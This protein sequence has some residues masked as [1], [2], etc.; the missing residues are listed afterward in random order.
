MDALIATLPTRVNDGLTDRNP[1]F[2]RTID[3]EPLQD[4]PTR[5]AYYLCIGPDREKG[6]RKA[7]N[8]ISATALDALQ[9]VPQYEVGGSFLM[10]NFFKIEGWIPRQTSKEAV[11]DIS[12]DAARRLERAFMQMMREEFF[13]GVATDDLNETTRGMIQVF[14]HEGLEIKPV[15]GEREWYATVSIRFHVWSGVVNSY[16]R[17]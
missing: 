8:A 11:Y 1:L 9:P 6:A 16:W 13:L 10:A 7:L 3:K 5:R 12:G 17:S 15:G 2:L 14:N 4:D